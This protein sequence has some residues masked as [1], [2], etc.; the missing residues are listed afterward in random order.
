MPTCLLITY[1]N[2]YTNSLGTAP[3]SITFW[4]TRTCTKRTN[5]LSAAHCKSFRQSPFAHWQGRSN[6]CPRPRHKTL[7][8]SLEKPFVATERVW[9]IFPRRS[10]SSRA[11]MLRPNRREMKKDENGCC[12]S[13]RKI[14]SHLI[15]RNKESGGIGVASPKMWGKWKIA[16]RPCL[17]FS[18]RD[19]TRML[20]PATTISWNANCT[21]G[22]CRSKPGIPTSIPNSS[23]ENC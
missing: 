19:C 17:W 10:V 1:D 21:T 13:H 11:P 23:D 4:G 12:C 8:N 22:K 16:V 6:T 15:A 3:H 20:V 2:T 5:H 9:R 7:R 18:M 14:C